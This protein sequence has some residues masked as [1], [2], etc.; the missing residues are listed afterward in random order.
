MAKKKF[1]KIA[2]LFSI[3]STS[4]FIGFAQSDK[5]S[6]KV[7]DIDNN[8]PVVGASIVIEQTKKG[9][10]SDAEGGFLPL[11]KQL[12]LPVILGVLFW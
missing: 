6:G 5:I 9:T 3:L 8:T 7:I 2:L 11:M 1:T 12:H 4:F 10:N